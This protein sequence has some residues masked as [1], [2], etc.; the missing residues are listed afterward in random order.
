MHYLG[1]SRS[2]S[3]Q[4]L[5]VL[6]LLSPKSFAESCLDDIVSAA[7]L[8]QFKVNSNG[9]VEDKKRN[10][11]WKVCLEGLSYK[12]SC[13]SGNVGNPHSWLG[14]IKVADGSRFA[15][16]SDWRLP[17]HKELVSIVDVSC[18]PVALNIYVFPY[19]AVQS[20]WSSTP[21]EDADIGEGFV[22]GFDY[23]T[24]KAILLNRKAAHGAVRLVRDL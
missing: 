24:R 19:Q 15:G 2:L 13:S 18:R 17:N 22:W 11:M 14:A 3:I 5:F 16:Y 20:V 9:T 12:G 21:F 4:V 23:F 7:G 6:L 10:L 1:M 8:S